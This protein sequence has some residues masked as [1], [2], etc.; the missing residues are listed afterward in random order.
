MATYRKVP[1]ASAVG[2]WLGFPLADSIVGVLITLAILR[3]AWDA[4]NRVFLRVLDGIDPEVVD[5][6]QHALEQQPHIR[7]VS[8]VRGRWLG[9][10]LHA[11]V[12]LAVDSNLSISEAHEIS[13]QASDRIMRKNPYLWNV[14]I[15]V[16]PEDASG[17]AHH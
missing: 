10:Q 1:A 6:I 2:I 16:D 5:E 14:V 3:I 7:D 13:L 9:H 15:H 12:N 11:E 8:S 4:G 17:E